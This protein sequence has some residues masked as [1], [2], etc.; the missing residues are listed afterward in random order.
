MIISKNKVYKVVTNIG[1]MNIINPIRIILMTCLL[2]YCTVIQ[3]SK[4]EQSDSLI[5]DWLSIEQQRNAIIN[6]WYQQQPLLEQR[7]VLLKQEQA[8]LEKDISTDSVNDTD[9]EKKRAQLLA[10]QNNMESAQGKLESLLVKYYQLVVELQ[11]RL[12]PPLNKAWQNKLAEGDLQNADT[13]LC[14]STLLELLEQLNDYQHRISH[15]QSALVLPSKTGNKEIMVHQLYLG[16][17]QAWYVSFDGSLVGRGQPS[18]DGWQWLAD[19]NVDSET[20]LNAIAMM[21]RKTE[22]TFLQLPITLSGAH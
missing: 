13:T 16:L 20:V 5:K 3:A 1:G 11:V 7:L 10:S 8:Q 4:V 9:V 2:S 6:D 18:P 21:E 22:A 19:E 14:F 17:S 12:P 15:V